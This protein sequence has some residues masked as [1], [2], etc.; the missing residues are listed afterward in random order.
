MITIKFVSG[1]QKRIKADSAA[2]RDGVLVLYVY[3]KD[4]SK[5]QS[6]N[7]FPAKIIDWARLDNGTVIVGDP[8]RRVMD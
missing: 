7:T 4:R 5:L 3:T 6:S 8:D 2:L 1:E